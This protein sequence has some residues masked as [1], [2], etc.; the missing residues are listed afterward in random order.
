MSDAPSF[1]IHGVCD[2]RFA[3]VRVA[4]EQNF[5]D[6]GEL[7][8]SVAV[9]HDDELVVDLWGGWAD[10][11][12]SR[13]WERDTLVMVSS[14][15]KIP[16]SVVALMLIDR[17]LVE[18][19][20]PV[21]TYWP[22]FGAAGKESVT[23]RHVLCHEAG[24]PGFEQPFAAEL[25][26]GDWEACVEH[27]A[28]Q[29][30]WWEPGSQSGYHSMTFAHLVGELV[31]RTTGRTY[32]DFLHG[33][34]IGPLGADFRIG[35]P[36]TVRDRVA[37]LD[38]PE[39]RVYPAGPES[40]AARAD[41]GVVSTVVGPPPQVWM[42]GTNPSALGFTNARA[43]ARVGAVLA[44]SGASQGRRFLSAET[45]ALA[46]EEQRYEYDLVME[47]PVRWGLGFG[48]A[49]AEVPLP[50]PRSV[51]W[52]GYGGSTFVADP[53]SRTSWSYTP[54]RFISDRAGDERG[55]AIGG[56]AIKSIFGLG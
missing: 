15:S 51:H 45:A 14:T 19:D 31:R 13:P 34:L 18:L 5:I 41:S 36:P 53:D 46:A 40:F 3:A 11:A 17:E 35:A 2:E 25:I 30:P 47:A 6:R 22:E 44:G 49:S 1:E 29:A 7:G 33:E 12:R 26:Y 20:E 48:L 24:I 8:A 42:A 54:N 9:V 56:A 21:A 10:V 27:L 43:I 23:V 28:R 39:P 37:D 32:D 4:F 38:S 52:G 50:F 16:A 55:V